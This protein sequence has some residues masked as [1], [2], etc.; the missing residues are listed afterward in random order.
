MVICLQHSPHKLDAMHL[1]RLFGGGSKRFVE[2]VCQV[3]IFETGQNAMELC[4]AGVAF[5]DS[6]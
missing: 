2:K 3:K 5:A 6:K 4:K 1:T